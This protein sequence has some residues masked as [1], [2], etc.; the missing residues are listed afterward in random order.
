M[1]VILWSASIILATIWSQLNA[2]G[3]GV[4]SGSEPAPAAHAAV[5]TCDRRHKIAA[6]RQ[7]A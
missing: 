7:D 1:G 6:I 3:G 2:W 5:K 4:A